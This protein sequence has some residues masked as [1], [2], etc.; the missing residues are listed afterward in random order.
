MAVQGIWSGT[1]SFS[2]VAIPVQLVKAI[3]PGR[4]SFHLLHRKDYSPLARRMFCPEEGVMVPP[5]EIIRGYEIGPDKYLLITDEELES[6][7]PERSRSIEI[8]EFIDM[9][10]VDPIYYDHPYYL[11]PMKGGEKA[12]R[13]LAEVMRRTNKA[14]L[15][16]FVLHEREYLVAVKSTEGALALITLHYPEEIL[17]GEDLAPPDET[18]AAEEKSRLKKNI[19]QMMKDFYPDKYAD[20]RREKIVDLL[21][22]KGKEKAPVEAPEAEEAEAEGPPDLIAALEESMRE[23]KKNR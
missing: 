23:M 7:S 16:K 10:E 21:K 3:E 8:I 4:V 5:E 17:P 18:L 15:A 14:G 11:V 13:L 1:I 6:V 19:E 20:A 9:E 22:Q 12:Y 2:L